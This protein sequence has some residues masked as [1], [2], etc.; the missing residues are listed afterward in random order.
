MTVTAS[1]FR[2][3]FPE[4]ASTTN[5]PDSLV[6][7]WIGLAGKL[8]SEDRWGDVLDY[9]IELFVAHNLVLE[10]QAAKSAA[11]GAVPGVASGAVAQKTVDKVSVSYDTASAMEPGAGHWNLTTYGQRWIRLVSMFGAGGLQL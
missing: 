7:F 1:S 6:T 5:Y 9:G 11:T 8:H 3:D 4:F 10:R 2:T